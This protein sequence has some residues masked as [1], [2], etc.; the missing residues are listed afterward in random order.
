MTEKE[1]ECFSPL[2]TTRI[3]YMGHLICLACYKILQVSGWPANSSSI[4]LCN[5]VLSVNKELNNKEK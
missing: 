5:D 2:N 3:L 1:I 4:R